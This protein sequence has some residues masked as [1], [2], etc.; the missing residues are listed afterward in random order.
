M[1]ATPNASRSV[2]Y[3]LG[4]GRS[5]SG[6]LGRV[7]STID[8]AVFA[9]ELRRIWSRGIRPGRTCGCGRLHADCPV[10]STLLVDH[11]PF[12]EPR[13][14]QVAAAQRA[15][16]PD[17]LGWRAALR[18]RRRTTA[19]PP[20]TPAGTYLDAYTRLHE[21][22]A[23]ASGATVVIDSSKS[24]A[25][26]ALLA[27]RTEIPTVVIQLIRDPRGVVHSL[28]DHNA[29]RA[30]PLG[31]RA[32]AVRG[33]LRWVAKHLTNEALRARYGPDRSM[34]VR[35]ERLVADPRSVV[36]RVAELVRLQPP[37]F[38]LA[39]GVPIPV[40][41][42][43]GPDGSRRRRFETEEIV[44]RLDARWEREMHPV[45]RT[46]VTLL[47]LPLLVRYGYPVRT[48]RRGEAQ[49]ATVAGT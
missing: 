19:P 28:I 8:G 49:T 14:S 27:V 37:A 48:P 45:D 35:Y 13:R 31:R 34:V 40:P 2:V 25:D 23:A 24:A 47:T 33:A 29:S 4:P 15:V 44:L 10:W 20:E 41:E 38:E 6:V 5:G 11:A 43:H 26:A 22:F 1:G 3:I 16:A 36:D 21:A 17:H 7:L 42:V 9:G 18:Q 12:V 30:G 39:A 46:L 32:M